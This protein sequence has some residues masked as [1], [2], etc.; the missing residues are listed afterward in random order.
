MFF[1]RKNKKRREEGG[2]SKE[3]KIKRNRKIKCVFLFFIYMI[4]YSG[5]Y[6]KSKFFTFLPFYSFS[7]K[8]FFVIFNLRLRNLKVLGIKNLKSIVGGE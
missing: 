4:Q 2:Q 7:S 5:E 8:R 6:V 3:R 1:L